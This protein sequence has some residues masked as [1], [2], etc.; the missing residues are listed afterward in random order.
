[1]AAAKP[2]RALP[3]SIIAASSLNRSDESG[4]DGTATIAVTVGS[5]VRDCVDPIVGVEASPTITNDRKRLRIRSSLV[6]QCDRNF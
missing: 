5:A 2:M 1:M 4:T 3:T 6:L